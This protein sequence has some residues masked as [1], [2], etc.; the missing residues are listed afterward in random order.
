M[1]DTP[2][3]L[4]PAPPILPPPSASP[5]NKR[6]GRLGLIV[7][8]SAVGVVV[9]GVG[10][11][12]GIRALV[13]MNA[14]ATVAA[15]VESA[16]PTATPLG[17]TEYVRLDGFISDPV[18]SS[19]V[20]LELPAA[21]GFDGGRT[22]ISTAQDSP[23]EW[24]EMPSIDNASLYAGQMSASF[25]FLG[26]CMSFVGMVRDEGDPENRWAF[27]EKAYG[28]STLLLFRDQLGVQDPARFHEESL[29]GLPYHEEGLGQIPF[30][31]YTIPAAENSTQSDMK[32][33]QGPDYNTGNMMFL[34]V[35]CLLPGDT[36]KMWDT[37][38]TPGNEYS[39][40]VDV[41]PASTG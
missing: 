8:L 6:G 17:T 18:S 10:A 4:P 33:V 15:P 28:V 39:V 12:F 40:Y 38:T 20:V 19:R 21:E 27:N 7:G 32:V 30:F 25:G 23:W 22:V 26:S 37:M 34:S 5:E 2:P 36:E 13:G 11:F 3:G 14:P 31:N 9:I 41:L 29:L 35:A 24:K 16:T 1:T